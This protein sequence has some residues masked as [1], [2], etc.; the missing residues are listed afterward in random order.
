MSAAETAREYLDRREREERERR[1]ADVSAMD[2]QQLGEQLEWAHSWQDTYARLIADEVVAGQEP[3][4]FLIE[5][6]IAFKAALGRA[7]AENSRRCAH[8]AVAA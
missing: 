3:S 7:V 5:G 1:E 2:H 4:E 8:H 6:Y